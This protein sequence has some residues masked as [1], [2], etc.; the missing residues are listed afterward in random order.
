MIEHCGWLASTLPNLY[1]KINLCAKNASDRLLEVLRRDEEVDAPVKNKQL[2]GP[3]AM[4]NQLYKI[5]D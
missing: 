4:Q 5:F 2:I 1:L 3:S